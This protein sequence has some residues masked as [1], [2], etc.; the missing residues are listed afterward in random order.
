MG[1]RQVLHRTLRDLDE[2][3]R[4]T[5]RP[6]RDP[7]RVGDDFD[8]SRILPVHPAVQRNQ[9]D[10]GAVDRDLDLL[11]EGR[12]LPEEVAGRLVLERQPEVVLAVRDEVVDDRDSAPRA[13]GGARDVPPLLGVARDLVRR[14]GGRRVGI[15]QREAA[16]LAGRSQIG[17]EQRCGQVLHVGD[18]VEAGAHRLA[19]QVGGRIDLQAQQVMDRAFVFGPV[20]ALEGA[21]ARVGTARGRLVDGLLHP[22]NKGRD[23]VFRR[24]PVPRRRHH[25]RPQL[26]DHLF[27]DGTVRGWVR[28]VEFLEV[29]V[30]DQPPFVVAANA[31]L[32]DDVLGGPAGNGG[33]GQYGGRPR[34][35][36]LR[37]LARRAGPGGE[38]K[39]QY[40]HEYQ[41]G[42]ESCQSGENSLPV[43]V[44]VFGY[45]R[46]EAGSARSK[47]GGFRAR[48][49][50][51]V[52]QPP[53]ASS[54]T[55][56]ATRSPSRRTTIRTSSPGSNSAS[57]YM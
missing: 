44:S 10:A 54:T 53:P 51:R 32:L 15:A 37:R 11:V 31:V 57:A 30:A 14:L 39:S 36:Q 55:V 41:D 42:A 21:M 12:G 48:V 25:S 38:G 45:C 35:E 28:G 43:A 52:P 56:N 8:A 17:I 26:A 4:D 29:E 13:E 24:P 34:P 46:T 3:G 6:R 5:V 33:S 50:A 47:P 9:R 16:N 7:D 18:V 20:Q 2:R 1:R 27:G 23:F 40:G 22:G 19:R 49:S